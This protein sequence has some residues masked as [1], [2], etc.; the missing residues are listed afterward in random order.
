VAGPAPEPPPA[1]P[2]AILPA[3]T[4]RKKTVLKSFGALDA[5]KPK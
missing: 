1:P 3:A 5:L 4:A 2:P